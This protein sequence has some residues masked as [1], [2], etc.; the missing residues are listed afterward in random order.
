MKKR[1]FIVMAIM[2]VYLCIRPALA[3]KI[4]TVDGVT[5]V[6]NGKKPVPLRGSPPRS[7]WSKNWPSE[8][9]ETRTRPFPR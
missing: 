7:S 5:V 2:A 4:K 3:Q 8:A 6:S 1:V 9:A